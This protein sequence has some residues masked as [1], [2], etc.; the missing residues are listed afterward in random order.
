[1][2]LP[3]RL[4]TLLLLLNWLAFAGMFAWTCVA[5]HHVLWWLRLDWSGWLTPLRALTSLGQL[6]AGSL[7]I[8][9]LLLSAGGTMIWAWRPLRAPAPAIIPDSDEETPDDTRHTADITQWHL[10]KDDPQQAVQSDLHAKLQRLKQSL[11]QI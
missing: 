10:T 5:Q 2:T 7:W 4:P 8:L 3:I 11:E 1:M 9:W 6:P